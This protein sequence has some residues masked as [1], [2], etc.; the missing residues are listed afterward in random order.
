M[1]YRL[2]VFYAEATINELIKEVLE[3][4]FSQLILLEEN[5]NILNSIIF[6]K[7]VQDDELG[8]LTT[9]EQTLDSIYQDSFLA[10]KCLVS[11]V[12][13][14]EQPVEEAIPYM[15]PLLSFLPQY[16]SEKHYLMTQSELLIKKYLAT[17]DLLIFNEYTTFF[18]LSNKQKEILQNLFKFNN[19]VVA[20][21]DYM[22]VHRNTLNYQLRKIMQITGTDI[23]QTDDIFLLQLFLFV[24]G[25]HRNSSQN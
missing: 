22:Y 4:E 20:T 1:A 8:L 3:T 5:G 14:A 13:S 16:I 15:L 25:V 12:F 21:S 17:N 10:I 2:Y 24:H 9:I 18:E 11:R 7:D 6:L 19:N 23:R